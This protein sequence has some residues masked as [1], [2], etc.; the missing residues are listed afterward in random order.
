MNPVA[1]RGI[2]FVSHSAMD[3]RGDGVQIMVHRGYAYVGHGFSNGI[4]TLDVRDAKHPK[5][6]DFI[7]CPPGTRAL[8]L[9]THEDLLLT[10]NAPSV[11]TMQQFQTD[12]DYF[13]GSPADRL[14]GTGN[15]FT[16]GIRVFDISKPEKPREIGFMPVEGIGPHRIWYVGGRYAYASIHF[17]DFTDHILAIIDMADPRKPQVVGR[18]WIPGMWRG[19]GETPTWR[20]GRRYALHHALVAGNI[21]YGAWRDGGLTVIDVADPA[22][23]KILAH[24]NTDPPFGGGTH[25]PLPLPERNLLVVADEPASANCQDGLRY[26]W[27]YD[28][29]EPSNPVSIATFPQPGEADY[30]AKGGFFGAHNMHENRPGAFQSSRLIF[31]TYYNAGVR[32]FDIEDQF[33]PR[34]VAFYVPPNPAR[35]M[36]PRPNRPQVIQS[37]DCY[38]DRDGLMYLTDP[39]AGLNILQFEGV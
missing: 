27:M 28:V 15:Q 34:E 26:M 8:H 20:A 38:V 25:S 16:P 2:K 21:A 36:D 19:G 9:Q 14:K 18:C 4:T 30:C 32:V 13:G 17:A 6:V 35:M 31:A 12:K 7:A 10:V 1:S 33:R 29:R 22:K 37:A 11:W 5:V 24:R 3:G 23:P 39:N